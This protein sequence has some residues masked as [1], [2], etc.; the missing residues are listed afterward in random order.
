MPAER[1]LI[2]SWEGERWGLW[3]Y[4]HLL[5]KRNKLT[6]GGKR[7]GWQNWRA[8]GMQLVC[9][10]WLTKLA[11]YMRSC[12]WGRTEGRKRGPDRLLITYLKKGYVDQVPSPKHSKESQLL[13]WV[14]LQSFLKVQTASDK[15]D[16]RNPW[17]NLL[18]AGGGAYFHR[19]LASH[20]APCPI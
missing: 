6:L 19:A 12:L 10:Q 5:E 1:Q 9:V 14:K 3:Q 7:E 16:F 4:L 11:R 8:K 13:R 20:I 18:P 17:R 2:L 15:R